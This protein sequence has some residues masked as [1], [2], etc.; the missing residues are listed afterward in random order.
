M[1]NLR[2]IV[3]LF[4]LVGGI[5]S[6]SWATFPGAK[7]D[8]HG[9]ERFDFELDGVACRVVTPKSVATGNPWIWR[10]RFWGHEPQT[11]L[12][13]LEKGFHVA[14]CDV[15]DLWGNAEA[16]RRWDRFYEYLTDEHGLSRRPALLGMSRGGLIV[17]HWAIQH[18]HQVSCIYGDAPAMGIR[19]YVRN[20]MEGDPVLER[21]RGWLDAHGLTLQAAKEYKLDALDRLAP[22]AAAKVPLIHVCGDADEAVPYEEHTAELA[23]RYERLGGAIKVIVKKGGKHHPHS[24][25]DPTPIV[26]FIVAHQTRSDSP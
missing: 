8:W 15:A 19:P 10:A 5:T 18:P 11:E 2:Y 3:L 14:Y 23:R 6:R 16:I 13:L 12:A 26:D 20:A 22:L 7:S 24:L 21:L 9:F 1:L 4:L 17:Y 25:K